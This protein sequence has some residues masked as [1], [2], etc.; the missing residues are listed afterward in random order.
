MDFVAKAIFVMP[1]T[2]VADVNLALRQVKM[3]N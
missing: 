2:F 1:E 3:N